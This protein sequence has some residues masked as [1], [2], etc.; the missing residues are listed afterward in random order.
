M[1]F[2]LNKMNCKRARFMIFKKIMK[3]QKFKKKN[4]FVVTNL[5][6]DRLRLRIKR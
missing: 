4:R 6:L 5:T 2:D 1:T 3:V